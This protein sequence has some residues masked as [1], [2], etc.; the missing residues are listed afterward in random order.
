MGRKDD[1][2]KEKKVDKVGA[3]DA[4]KRVKSTEA[5]S[6]VDKVKGTYAVSKVSA[7]SGVGAASG[8]GKISLEQRE[9][10]MGMI[11]EEA[12]KLTA[13]GVIP[14]SQKEVVEQAVKMF[15]DASLIESGD[16]P[17]KR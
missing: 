10:Y 12:A 8:I 5:V 4:T 11:T 6:E 13:E 14:K 2:D 3:S 7:V 1:K 16:D 9:K 17:K 15:I